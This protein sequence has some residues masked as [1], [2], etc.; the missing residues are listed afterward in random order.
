MIMKKIFS[1]TAC[2][3]ENANSYEIKKHCARL[4]VLVI[5]DSVERLMNLNGEKIFATI[6]ET[7]PSVFLILYSIRWSIQQTKDI[8]GRTECN[9]LEKIN[10]PTNDIFVVKYVRC[11]AG[12]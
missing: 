8:V 10:F 7:K 5:E 1:S 3:F 12:K 6:N 11:L 2:S 9:E 4:T